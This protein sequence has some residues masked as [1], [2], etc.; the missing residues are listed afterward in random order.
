MKI[1]EMISLL[2]EYVQENGDNDIWFCRDGEW[3]ELKKDDL[4]YCYGDEGEDP[5]LY[6]GI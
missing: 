2:Q 3:I 6:V 1:T 4:N 5:G